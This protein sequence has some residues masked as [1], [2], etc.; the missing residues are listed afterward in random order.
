MQLDIDFRLHFPDAVGNFMTHFPA[1]SRGLIAAARLSRRTNIVELLREYDSQEHSAEVN[2]R[3]HLYALLALLYLL[4]SAN[5]RHKAKRS[6]AELLNSFLCFKPQQTSIDLVLSE[7]LHKQ[8]FLLCL[9]TIENPGVFYL[10]LDVKAISLGACGVLKAVDT[11]FKA[12]YV[13]WVG[14]AKSLELFMEFLQKVVYKIECTKLSSRVGE[15][16]SSLRA[17]MSAP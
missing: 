14:Y 3:E 15:L 7:K 1:Y 9:G 2:I 13:Y 4:P 11:L 5:T 6:S 10:I 16:D 12:H 8:P 17:F